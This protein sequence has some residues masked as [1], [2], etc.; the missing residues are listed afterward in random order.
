MEYLIPPLGYRRR[1]PAFKKQEFYLMAFDGE[2][3]IGLILNKENPSAERLAAAESLMYY[4]ASQACDALFLVAMD[5]SEEQRLREEAASSLGCLWCE[6]GIDY[7]RLSVLPVACLIEAVQDFA[8]HKLRIDAN[9]IG[10]SQIEFMRRIEGNELLMSLVD[11]K[12]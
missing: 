10:K 8:D 7:D 12:P 11:T 5:E 6:L 1:H 4:P 9:L 3:C 2:S